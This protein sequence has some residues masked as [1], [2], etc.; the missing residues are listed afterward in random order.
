MHLHFYKNELQI[1]WSKISIPLIN[2][3][4]VWS[5]KINCVFYGTISQKNIKIHS[6]EKTGFCSTFWPRETLQNLPCL[7]KKE[8]Q[9]VFFLFF[10]SSNFEFYPMNALVYVDIHI[11]MAKLIVTRNE[12]RKNYMGFLLRKHSKFWSVFLGQ[13]VQHMHLIS[14]ECSVIKYTHYQT[15]ASNC[16]GRHPYST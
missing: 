11:Y 8:T 10:I 13:R 7:C 1:K 15:L 16:L 3:M 2:R 14:E 12:K 9:V 4:K 5:T 6:S